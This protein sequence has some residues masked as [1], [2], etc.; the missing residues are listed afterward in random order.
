MWVG[1]NRRVQ[2]FDEETNDCGILEN[3]DVGGLCYSVS[4]KKVN[5][6]AWSELIWLRWRAVFNVVMNLCLP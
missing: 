2:G 3:L 1:M 4:Q 6:R 5:R